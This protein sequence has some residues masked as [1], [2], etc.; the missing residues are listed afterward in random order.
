MRNKKR[1]DEIGF[2]YLMVMS[3]KSAAPKRCGAAPQN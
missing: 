3:I 1:V 2:G